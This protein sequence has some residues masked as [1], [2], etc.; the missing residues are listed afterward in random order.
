MGPLVT[1]NSSTLFNKALELIEAH[2]L[3]SFPPERIDVVVHPQS[4][5]HSMVQFRDGA[6][7]AQVSPP[8]MR[9]P[10]ALALAWP[11]R[12]NGVIPSNNWNAAT[13]WHFEPLDESVFPA[14]QMARQALTASPL[15]PA[16]FNGA[17][18]A[19]V[20][21]FLDGRLSYLGITDTVAAVLQ[22]F[23]SSVLPG[24]VP[25]LEQV[26]AADAWGRTQAEVEGNP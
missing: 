10:I 15:H 8:D 11:E 9:L 14:V 4:Q 6:V 22:R 17:N 21:A 12:L 18:E 26:M 13:Q 2:L 23:T 19:C 1:V 16:V 20:E 7:I 25:S 3:F 5:V 24:T